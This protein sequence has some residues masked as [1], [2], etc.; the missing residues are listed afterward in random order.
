MQI[1][2]IIFILLMILMICCQGPVMNSKPFQKFRSDLIT[3]QILILFFHLEVTPDEVVSLVSI[4][5]V[6]QI[7]V[8]QIVQSRQVISI[9]DDDGILV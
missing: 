8:G 2:Q 3:I 6:F 7:I 4:S 1:L 9:H 5:A